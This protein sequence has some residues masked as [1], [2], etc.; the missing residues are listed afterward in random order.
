MENIVIIGS[1]VDYKELRS[2][3]G[4]GRFLYGNYSG[5]YIIIYLFKF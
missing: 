3:W 4:D 1:G 5:G 2:F